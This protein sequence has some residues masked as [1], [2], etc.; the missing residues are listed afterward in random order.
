MLPLAATF[1][2]VSLQQKG[3]EDLTSCLLSNPV[4]SSWRQLVIS[5]HLIVSQEK[6][7][8][9]NSGLVLCQPVSSSLK[10]APCPPGS[11]LHFTDSMLPCPSQVAGQHVMARTRRVGAGGGKQEGGALLPRNDIMVTL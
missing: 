6:L 1:P 3:R 8:T 7:R 5:G 2:A 10:T 4:F 11:Y 9:P